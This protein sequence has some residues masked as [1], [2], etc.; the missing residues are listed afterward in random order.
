MTY[1]FA[2]MALLAAGLWLFRPRRRVPAEPWEG[3]DTVEPVDQAEL[4]AAERE[5]QEL[6]ATRRPE[7]GFE[8]DDWGPGTGKR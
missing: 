8:G 1:L 3:E 5:I 4:D 7:D 6:D 2:T